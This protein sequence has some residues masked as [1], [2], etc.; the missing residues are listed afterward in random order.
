MATEMVEKQEADIFAGL[1]EEVRKGEILGK[2]Q[3]QLDLVRRSNEE[4]LESLKQVE[5]QGV[6][7]QQREQEKRSKLE[8]ALQ[9]GQGFVSYVGKTVDFLTST[10][11]EIDQYLGN[12]TSF[13]PE[14]QQLLDEGKALTERAGK[15]YVRINPFI[16]KGKLEEQVKDLGKLAETRRTERILKTSLSENITTLLTYYKS[17]K[18]VMYN[19]GIANQKSANEV[20]KVRDATMAKL[21]VNERQ[22]DLWAADKKTQETK[23]AELDLELT[24]LTGELR[25]AAE[26]KRMA[27]NDLLEKAKTQEDFYFGIVKNARADLEYQGTVL[28]SF[29]DVVRGINNGLNDMQQKIENRTVLFTNIE[30]IIKTGYQVK[31]F[32]QADQAMDKTTKK[33]VETA[34]VTAEGLMDE[35]GTRTTAKAMTPDELRTWQQRSME[36]Q[37]SYDRL[38]GVAKEEYAAPAP[39]ASSA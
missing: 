10:F 5:G 35:L 37:R 23:L 25:T 1:K 32:G 18:T 39:G 38:V 20:Q 30:T 33:I 4:Y 36:T 8:I 29:R 6:D 2:A 15:W 14:E 26:T 12:I 11:G 16:D 7:G 21:D 17:M 13:R 31:S 9:S 22:Y 3:A 28:A 27:V 34:V 19:A 24:G